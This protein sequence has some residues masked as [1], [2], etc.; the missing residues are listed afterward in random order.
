MINTDWKDKVVRYDPVSKTIFSK[1]GSYNVT[2]GVSTKM[3]RTEYG[4]SMSLY[5]TPDN[6][7]EQYSRPIDEE[8]HS[9]RQDRPI[10]Y[11]RVSPED[12]C[13]NEGVPTEW[14]VDPDFVQELAGRGDGLDESQ[15][16]GIER[17][18]EIL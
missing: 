16:E 6:E 14:L 11:E 18:C 13:F 5:A 12:R 1:D 9:N 8:F 15:I 7:S 17:L 4:W 2:T 10:S 3:T